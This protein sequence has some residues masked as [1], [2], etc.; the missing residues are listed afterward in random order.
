MQAANT[1]R[2]L[3]KLQLWTFVWP[4]FYAARQILADPQWIRASS[5][6]FPN[7][8]SRHIFPDWED[9]RPEFNLVRLG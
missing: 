8:E 6:K 7:W 3:V 5:R 1:S 2:Q 4:F 9:A